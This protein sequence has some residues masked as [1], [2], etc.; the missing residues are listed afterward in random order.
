MHNPRVP[1]QPTMVLACRPDKPAYVRCPSC[2]EPI[3]E[4]ELAYAALHRTQYPDRAPLLVV[5]NGIV[6][7]GTMACAPMECKPID[8][9]TRMR[10]TWTEGRR[11]ITSE[12][13]YA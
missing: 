6:Y 11:V 13:D 10:Q 3:T 7:H 4:E 2:F 1:K 8:T 9:S 5:A 12:M